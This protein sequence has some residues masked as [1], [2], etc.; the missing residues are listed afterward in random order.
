MIEV[1]N[2]GEDTG[3]CMDRPCNYV[4]LYDFSNSANGGLLW[5]YQ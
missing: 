5:V 4:Y 3:R 1:L 2:N